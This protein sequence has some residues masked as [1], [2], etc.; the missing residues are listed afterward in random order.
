MPLNLSD[1]G[2][3]ECEIGQ[4]VTSD[5]RL[6]LHRRQCN[7]RPT[8]KSLFVAIFFSLS[9]MACSSKKSVEL[10]PDSKLES[11]IVEE[12]V[13]PETKTF[14][15]FYIFGPDVNT[16]Y[17]C[18]DKKPYWVRG[19][20]NLA[21]QLI[22]E[23]KSLQTEAYEPL[24]IEFTGRI[25]PFSED[26][27]AYADYFEAFVSLQTY[28]QLRPRQSGDCREEEPK[29]E[30]TESLIFEESP[31]LIDPIRST[32]MLDR[33]A[34]E[35]SQ[36]F[37]I[38]PGVF[39]VF[40]AS[41]NDDPSQSQSLVQYVLDKSQGDVWR[42]FEFWPFGEEIPGIELWHLA[43]MEKYGYDAY[44][45]KSS[46]HKSLAALA[47]SQLDGNR[48]YFSLRNQS[49]EKWAEQNA[50]QASMFRAIYMARSQGTYPNLEW[51]LDPIPVYYSDEQTFAVGGPRASDP[52]VWRDDLKLYMTLGSQDP[53]GQ[54][55]I[56]IVDLDSQTGRLKGFDRATPGYYSLGDSIFHPVSTFGEAAFSFK[57]RDYYY[58]FLNIGRCC[59]GIESTSR[60]VVGRSKNIYGPYVDD[61][62]RSFMSY[63]NGKNYPGKKV[64]SS[65]ARYIGPG[66]AGVMS[67]GN[68][69]LAFSFHY[70]DAE[71]NG[72]SKFATRELA[73]D[74][75]GW[76]YI[77]ADREFD[78]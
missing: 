56:H 33:Q 54:P 53:Q 5:F 71:L 59:A 45:S 58:L 43:W 62:G 15:G 75:Q 52:Q 50:T 78:F 25:V 28:S 14:E 55:V 9:L 48:I 57:Y 29:E 20:S 8:V 74:S 24:F 47:P 38:M 76:P 73:F 30:I 19:D 4:V 10:E 31:A 32:T 40:S 77:V 46:L 17:L 16:V 49:G 51:V 22:P 68:G 13:L 39:S 27:A 72:V 23:A 11:L 2:S 6:L 66:H 42:R 63:Y 21:G 44:S 3:S 41:E 36:V 34:H 35:P 1:L 60:I 26:E 61:Q 65:Y 7:Y 12:P 18:S 69:R 37:E 64:L 67:Q 70:Y